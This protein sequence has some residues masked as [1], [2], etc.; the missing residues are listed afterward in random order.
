MLLWTI[1]SSLLSAKH[2]N[3]R[4]LLWRYNHI[5]SA[6]LNRIN[7][8]RDREDCPAVWCGDEFIKNRRN[9]WISLSLSICPLS[10]YKSATRSR[11]NPINDW[12]D[13]QLKRSSNLIPFRHRVPDDIPDLTSTTDLWDC[14]VHRPICTSGRHTS[15]IYGPLA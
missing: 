11:F 10:T 14:T 6:E 1:M 7:C 4:S 9:P 12:V 3:S 8:L 13:F 15:V 5:V 2:F